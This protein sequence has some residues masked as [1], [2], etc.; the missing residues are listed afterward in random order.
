M[1]VVGSRIADIVLC[2]VLSYL[3]FCFLLAKATYP[4]MYIRVLTNSQT[5]LLRWAAYLLLSLGAVYL[6]GLYSDPFTGLIVLIM[7][8]SSGQFIRYE[9]ESG[10]C[11]HCRTVGRLFYK[12][13]KDKKTSQ[14]TSAVRTKKKITCKTNSTSSWTDHEG[15]HH[16]SEKI[17][18]YWIPVRK[19]TVTTLKTWRNE[20]YCPDCVELI[21]YRKEE[22]TGSA[23]ISVE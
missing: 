18:E 9:L 5:L 11:P 7:I 17:T 22:V 2:L 21:H 16:V 13:Q 10:R 8:Y 15:K 4:L 14:S 23:D 6:L 20:Y 12:G 1:G 3:L 19:Q